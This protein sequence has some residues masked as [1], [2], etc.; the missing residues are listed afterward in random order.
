MYS[1][2]V[3]V[4]G[5]TEIFVVWL[6]YNLITPNEDIPIIGCGCRLQYDLKVSRSFYFTLFLSLQLKG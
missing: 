1:L 3:W 5:C 2:L 4:E 6:N